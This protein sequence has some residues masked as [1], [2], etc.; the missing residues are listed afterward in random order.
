M[1]FLVLG[2]GMMGRAAA[3]DLARSEGVE[4]VLLADRDQERL[5]AARDFVG[6]EKLLATPVDVTKLDA[7]VALMRGRDAALS[8]VPYRFNYLLARAA[9]AAN[10]NFCDLGGNN[11][12]VEQELELDP[13]ARDAGI[14]IVPDCGLAP[15]LVSILSA[16]AASGFDELEAI[17]LR[18]GGLPQH[19]K[20]PLNYKIVFSPAGLINEYKE[21][22]LVIRNGELET[23]PSMTELE[24]LE[25]PPPFGKL[26]A[27]VTSGG[28][29]TLPR[30]FLGKVK[31]LDYKTIRYKGHCQQLRTMLELGLGDEEPMTVDGQE[32]VPRRFFETLL[33]NKLSDDDGDVVLV[34]VV[35][36]GKRDGEKK[37][38]SY[39][40][41][42]H[43]DQERGL[44]AMMRMTA[45]PAAIVAQLQASGALIQKGAVPQELCVPP[46]LF[47]KELE[48]RGVKI[49]ITEKDCW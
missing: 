21:D 3:L 32:L 42:D 5:E 47:I 7:V 37:T 38:R 4:E 31:E 39:T 24:E 9:V 22:A 45:F 15:G 10:C 17:H 16:D 13:A 43:A 1:K 41:I 36:K 18:V 49:E 27:F 12:I 6:S 46:G 34:R 40:I 26:E 30:T 23:I 19:P 11:S 2:A 29:S 35:A 28:S 44:S 8:A 14:T 20:P 25:F 33:Q 48:K